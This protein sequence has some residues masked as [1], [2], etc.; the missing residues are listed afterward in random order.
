M[1]CGSL[2]NRAHFAF[3]HRTVFGAASSR[4]LSRQVRKGGRKLACDVW[5]G[6]E[7]GMG[8]VQG[9]ARYVQG[10]GLIAAAVSKD[11]FRTSNP[12]ARISP[13]SW[14]SEETSQPGA[15]R[16]IPQAW[17]GNLLLSLSKGHSIRGTD[18][19]FTQWRIPPQVKLVADDLLALINSDQN[20]SIQDCVELALPCRKNTETGRRRAP[21]LPKKRLLRRENRKWLQERR[22]G[23]IACASCPSSSSSASFSVF[24]Y[25][26]RKFLKLLG[27]YRLSV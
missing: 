19:P 21:F 24:E 7:R 16:R 4:G 10:I 17:G 6:K 23:F 11:S 13:A 1:A 9:I 18:V 2:P 14:K 27:N 22:R 20:G 15:P 3:C 25:P 26:F 5:R 8:C 12:Q